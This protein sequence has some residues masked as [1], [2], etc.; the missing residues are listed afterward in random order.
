[1]LGF[2]QGERAIERQSNMRL[3]SMSDVL[4]NRLEAINAEADLSPET[5]CEAPYAQ[6]PG[7]TSPVTEVVVPR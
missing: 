6:V 1:M 7:A 2:Q 4:A 3:E 5:A